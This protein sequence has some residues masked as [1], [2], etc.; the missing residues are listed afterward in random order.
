MLIFENVD[1]N[2]RFTK[3]FIRK[4]NSKKSRQE[5]E[6]VRQNK[7]NKIKR[8]TKQDRESNK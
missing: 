8:N 5:I 2:S 6:Q 7:S 3:L 4:K 1:K